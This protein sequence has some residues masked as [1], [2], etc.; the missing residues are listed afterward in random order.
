PLAYG[1][2]LGGRLD[3]LR[4]GSFG[5]R[6][7]LLEGQAVRSPAESPAEGRRRAAP[8]SAHFGLS[9]EPPM[10]R[11]VRRLLVAMIL[12]VVVYAAFALYRGLHEISESL[13]RFHWSAFAMA[14]GLAFGNYLTRFL[15]WEYYLARL[16]IK[17]VPKVDSL[18]TFLSG[19]V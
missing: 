6:V 1:S 13:E 19:L 8:G 14:C 2:P 17:G 12:G 9:G 4:R 18:L 16:G 15:K 10:S 3:R 5:D 11:L 7:L